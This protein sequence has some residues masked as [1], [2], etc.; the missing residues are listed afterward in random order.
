MTCFFLG[1]AAKN[2]DLTI[3][4]GTLRER[5][6]FLCA[7]G[8][9]D[10]ALFV[11]DSVIAIYPDEKNHYLLKAE[12]ALRLDTLPAAE[13]V[14]DKIVL[15]QDGSAVHY[16]L[17]LYQEKK[18]NY[19]LSE[20]EYNKAL[21]WNPENIRAKKSLVRILRIRGQYE[22]A[23]EIIKDE[24]AG[25]DFFLSFRIADLYER[26]GLSDSAVK[27]FRM[28]LNKN[29]YNRYAIVR[30]ARILHS[31]DN[32]TEALRVLH[33]AES[34]FPDD[35]EILMLKGRIL[36]ESGKVSTAWTI[37]EEVCDVFIDSIHPNLMLAKSYEKENRWGRAY[38]RY[39]ILKEIHPDHQLVLDGIART[40]GK[41]YK[42]GIKR[43]IIEGQIKKQA[44]KKDLAKGEAFNLAKMY[45]SI[46]KTD[47][48]AL[49]FTLSFCDSLKH[50]IYR[51]RMLEFADTITPLNHIS[52]LL[53]F[54]PRDSLIFLGEIDRDV[55]KNKRIDF[56]DGFVFKAKTRDQEVVSLRNSPFLSVLPFSR[57]KSP[58]YFYGYESSVGLI[59][60]DFSRALFKIDSL[61]NPVKEIV[62]DEF[63]FGITGEKDGSFLL[64]RIESDAN[65][66][67]N[68]DYFDG[69]FLYR[70]RKGNYKKL[71]K[72]CIEGVLKEAYRLNDR[73][74]LLVRFSVN[75]GKNVFWIEDIVDIALVDK[76]GNTAP[77]VKDIDD[78]KGL[79]VHGPRL[80]SYFCSKGLFLIR[81]GRVK[82]IW[83]G[84][85]EAGPVHAGKERFYFADKRG[86]LFGTNLKKAFVRK[87]KLMGKFIRP[88]HFE[89][90]KGLF[91][92]AIEED[93]DL[94]EKI[95][96]DDK[97]ALFC[98]QK[99][100]SIRLTPFFI[101][102]DPLII[103]S[104]KEALVQVKG[105]G[106]AFGILMVKL[107][108]DGTVE[109]VFEKAIKT[110]PRP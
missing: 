108:L 27:Y 103:N 24:V 10:S 52:R 13:T 56:L 7:L 64:G 5:V 18:G 22:K 107:E 17:G 101:T 98:M 84:T 68:L 40:K 21:F 12:I 3:E 36:L 23:A 38:R 29:P 33:E 31:M 1:C 91:Y 44:A 69:F 65:R 16:L 97:R 76:K 88:I 11:I 39:A 70:Y 99:N 53:G 110:A 106:S 61:G 96:Q 34:F 51:E 62:M 71:V 74:Y 95:N 57:A 49:F 58:D 89:P 30:L 104:G 43:R 28:T 47:S 50:D 42:S 92:T 25:A 9:P 87:I 4:F 2:K 83:K 72:A 46:G 85:L 75:E 48:A 93:T 109:R 102:A 32:G 59:F 86:R 67:G 100:R 37:L 77:L 35:P 41:I 54:R 78:F 90:S 63:T 6:D 66:N 20:I 105:M 94:D 80:F 82:R 81:K 14:I 79:Q 60:T 15:S 55:N 45:Q 8:R 19:Y 73:Q 26:S